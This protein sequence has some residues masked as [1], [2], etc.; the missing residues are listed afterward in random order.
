M[1]TISIVMKYGSVQGE[2]SLTGYDGWIVVDEISHGGMW[3]RTSTLGTTADMAESTLTMDQITLHRTWDTSSFALFQTFAEGQPQ[4]SVTISAVAGQGGQHTIAQYELSNVSITAW[5]MEH[6]GTGSAQETLTLTA[7]YLM[8][9][10]YGYDD[11]G[12]QNKSIPVP[13]DYTK[14]SSTG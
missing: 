10:G 8:V 6:H 13:Y 4:E 1:A 5:S 12:N 9:T 11:Q 2:A 7:S 3:T 14:A